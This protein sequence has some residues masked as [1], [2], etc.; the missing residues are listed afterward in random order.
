MEMEVY[1]VGSFNDS[2]QVMQM[3]VDVI[4]CPSSWN[5]A[6]EAVNTSHEH[7]IV[8]SLEASTSS[9]SVTSSSTSSS[10]L[11]IWRESSI[12]PDRFVHSSTPAQRQHRRLR[13][14]QTFCPRDKWDQRHTHTLAGSLAGRSE[15]KRYG[16]YE[17]KMWRRSNR[18]V[19]N[20]RFNAWRSLRMHSYIARASTTTVQ[21]FK[22]F[23]CQLLKL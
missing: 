8:L 7:T 16:K 9:S 22:Y 12:I 15:T 2:A 20:L 3:L 6:A 23:M 10:L 1:P 5:F 21:H 18:K 17:W 19:N 4:N 14:R 11:I 13:R